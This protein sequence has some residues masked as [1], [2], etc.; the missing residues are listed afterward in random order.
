MIGCYRA[1][2]WSSIM[3]GQDDVRWVCAGIPNIVVPFTADQPFWGN[4]VNA[5]GVG[6]KPILVDKLS[7]ENLT[8][9]MVEADS[10]IIR[11][12]VQLI[13]QDIRS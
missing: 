2:R 3:V 8:Q 5:I 12:R 10:N 1:A 7:V 13:G 11:K 9:A 4:R 6:P